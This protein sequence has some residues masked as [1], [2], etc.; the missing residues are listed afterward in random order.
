MGP[1]KAPEKKKTSKVDPA[2]GGD[3][4]P[5]EQLK[6]RQAQVISLQLQLGERAEELSKAISSK[7]DLQ[8]KVE[9]LV[10]DYEVAKKKTFEIKQD[11][12]RQYTSMQEDLLSKI[13]QLEKANSD[14]RDLLAEA[15]VKKERIIREKNAIIQMKDDEISDLKQKIDNMAD[16]FGDMLRETLDKMKERIEISSGNFEAPE[17][18]IQQ[19]I[20]ELKIDS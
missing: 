16:E 17:V 15:D 19:K 20:E 6:M 9:R 13:I 8:E 10:D 12:T 1:K 2:M 11:M 4:S 7:R 18:Q 5:E 14:L 3:A